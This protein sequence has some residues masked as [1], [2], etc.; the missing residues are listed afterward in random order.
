MDLAALRK[1]TG[2]DQAAFAELIGMSRRPY[3]EL[4]AGRSRTREVHRMAA[5]AASLHEAVRQRDITIA[6]PDVRRDALALARL[7][8]GETYDRS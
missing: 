6:E 5:R 7:I 3:Q 4:E 8:T 1:R 2:L